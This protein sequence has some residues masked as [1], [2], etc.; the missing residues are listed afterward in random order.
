MAT[1]QTR[2][3]EKYRAKKGIITKSIKIPKELNIEFIKACERAHVSQAQ[4]FKD[5]MRRFIEAHPE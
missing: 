3:T 1:A 4:V 5:C 2:P